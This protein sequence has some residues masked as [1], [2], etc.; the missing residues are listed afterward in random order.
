MNFPPPV[1]LTYLGFAIWLELNRRTL[2]ATYGSPERAQVVILGL[3][4]R[5]SQARGQGEA[6]A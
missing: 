4:S 5:F 1:P 2:E 3:L 6:R